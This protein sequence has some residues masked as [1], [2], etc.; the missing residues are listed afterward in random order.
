M[1][2][3]ERVLSIFINLLHGQKLKKKEL[4]EE[5]GVSGKSI[6]RDMEIIDKVIDKKL[7][8][9]LGNMNY[10]LLIMPKLK[11]RL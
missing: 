8:E 4:E 9:N 7:T 2:S 10:Y 1:N 3:Q 6:Q 5:F 11:T